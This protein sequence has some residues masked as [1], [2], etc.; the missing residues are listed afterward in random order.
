MSIKKCINIYILIFMS[1]MVV[2]CSNKNM[3]AEHVAENFLNSFY[4]GKG[5]AVIKLMDGSEGLDFVEKLTLRDIMKTLAKGNIGYYGEYP[6]S[7][8]THVVYNEKETRAKVIYE[9]IAND[10]VIDHGELT[11]FLREKGWKVR[12]FSFFD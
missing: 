10:Q 8:I 12:N 6:Y 4:S 3:D 9:V 1:L 7:K 11:L 5:G 2:A